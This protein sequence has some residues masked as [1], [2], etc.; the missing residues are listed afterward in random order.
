MS[1]A[2]E[3]KDRISRAARK[4]WLVV[5][6][7][8]PHADEKAE[9]REALAILTGE[10]PPAREVHPANLDL[11]LK[12]EL[13]GQGTNRPALEEALHKDHW[14]TTKAKLGEQ[15]FKREIQAVPVPADWPGPDDLD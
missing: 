15:D 12:Q 9:V 11:R 8:N 4:L 13:V 7:Q 1:E 3:L 10:R 14:E 6:N 5:N 2:E